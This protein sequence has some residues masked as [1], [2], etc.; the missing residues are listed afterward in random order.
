MKA[1]KIVKK[2]QA[3]FTLIEL[4]IV[5]AIIGILASIAIPQYQDHVAKSKFGAALG[6]VTAGETGVDTELVLVPDHT[7]AEVLDLSKLQASTANCTNTST[8]AVAGVTTLVCTIVGGSADVAGKKITL[9]RDAAGV[10]SC[11]T[12]AKQKFIGGTDKVC[13][14]A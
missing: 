1:L 7:A 5:V 11:A 10:W 4:M 13:K 2:T 6:E 9:S 3:G 14:G 12:D 8:A